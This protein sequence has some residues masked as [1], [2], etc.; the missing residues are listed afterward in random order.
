MYLADQ[1]VRPEPLLTGGGQERRLRAGT[2]NVAAA[3]GFGVAAAQSEHHLRDAS[4]IAALRDRLEREILA[5]APEAKMLGCD[6]ERLPN[7]TLFAVP[8]FA[9]EV[10]VVAFDL[11]GIAVSAGS[12]CSSGKVAA[13]HVVTAM[14]EAADIARSA[15]RV[16]LPAG[17]GDADIEAFIA[18]WHRIYTRMRASRAA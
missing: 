12:A 10:L 9:A 6:A 14:G 11:E 1:A 16:S 2:E 5:I 13:S 15:V 7:T 4:R 3:A 18:A 17:A 8:T